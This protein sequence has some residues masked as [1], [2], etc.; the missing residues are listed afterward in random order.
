MFGGC[1]IQYLKELQVLQNRAAQITCRVPPRYHRAAMFDKLGWFTVR[2]LVC[3]HSLLLVFRIRL[4]KEPEYLYRIFSNENR[5]KSIIV[6]NTNLTLAKTSFTFRAS[7]QWNLLPI[8]LRQTES[9]LIFKKEL[10]I[11]IAD[12]IPRFF[13]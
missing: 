5:R 8:D 11:W 1:D 12:T 10:K 7:K 6:P 2:Q 13:T 3:Y 4:S 9:I